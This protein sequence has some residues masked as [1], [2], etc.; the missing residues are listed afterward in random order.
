MLYLCLHGRNNYCTTDQALATASPK[1]VRRIKNNTGASDNSLKRYSANFGSTPKQ[2]N[3]TSS[4]NLAYSTST[5]GFL[6]RTSDSSITGQVQSPSPGFSEGDFDSP[7]GRKKMV[8]HAYEDVDLEQQKEQERKGLHSN[9]RTINWINHHTEMNW[10]RDKEEPSLEITGS[11]WAHKNRERQNAKEKVKSSAGGI[12]GGG[13]RRPNRQRSDQ[14]DLV[15]SY[16]GPSPHHSYRQ[17]NSVP[18][19]PW[20]G[21][22]G[23]PDKIGRPRR[24]S[25][26]HAMGDPADVPV[27]DTSSHHRLREDKFSI[28]HSEHLLPTLHQRGG[29]ASSSNSNRDDSWK[30]ESYSANRQYT[31]RLSPRHQ[32]QHTITSKYGSLQ[33]DL[34]AS[35]TYRPRR[36]SESS[37][38]SLE[39][40]GKGYHVHQHSGGGHIPDPSDLTVERGGHGYHHH[41]HSGGLIQDPSVERGGR[42]YRR[43]HSGGHPSDVSRER[44][45][46]GYQ[47]Q[48]LG[49]PGGRSHDLRPH[50]TY[51][52]DRTYGNMIPPPQRE[53]EDFTSPRQRQI[54]S[55]L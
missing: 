10:G 7:T 32:H 29:G 17:Q 33:R 15:S 27:R 24:V 46:R 12:G 5:K 19:Q 52:N 2:M 1:T 55:Y 23:L 43:Q 11:M 21:T 28:S 13:G 31:S 25:Y 47:Q 6:Q 44:G 35:A 40:R 30:G 51:S 20:T 36:N 8:R 53:D 54:E 34:T 26:Q 49:G 48:H 39:R 9:S 50:R 4:G 42:G 45:G 22:N 3:R 18:A 38:P 37:D 14:R 16:H 41:Q